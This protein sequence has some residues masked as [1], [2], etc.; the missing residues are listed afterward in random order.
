MVSK[1]III[2]IILF[3]IVIVSLVTTIKPIQVG[4]DFSYNKELLNITYN[5]TEYFLSNYVVGFPLCFDSDLEKLGSLISI[6]GKYDYY[7]DDIENP[8]YILLQKGTYR[9]SIWFSKVNF[10]YKDCYVY[11]YD[12]SQAIRYSDCYLIESQTTLNLTESQDAFVSILKLYFKEYPSM[13]IEVSLYEV[14]DKYYI[15]DY[16]NDYYECSNQFKLILNDILID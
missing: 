1:K 3:I 9:D 4:N 11:I 13:Y 5:N 14:N 16:L 10:D 7:V 12:N 6:M 2:V 8:K 15:K